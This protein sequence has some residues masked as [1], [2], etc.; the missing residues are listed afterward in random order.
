MGRTRAERS[1]GRGAE[2]WP[3]SEARPVGLGAVARTIAGVSVLAVELGG[4]IGAPGVNP[5][6]CGPG[7]TVA[8]RARRF[9]AGPAPRQLIA[10]AGSSA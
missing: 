7:G 6:A 10:P 5:L 4:R 9:R 8:A 2:C 1:F 3:A